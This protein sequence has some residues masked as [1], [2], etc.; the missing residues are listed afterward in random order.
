[1]H[2]ASCKMKFCKPF[3]RIHIVHCSLFVVLYA[4]PEIQTAPHTILTFFTF[5]CWLQSPIINKFQNSAFLVTTATILHRLMS[6][7]RHHHQPIGFLYLLMRDLTT[8][9]LLV[10]AVHFED[11]NWIFK[12]VYCIFCDLI[13]CRL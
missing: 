6:K 2:I 3:K 12:T 9:S 11:Q 5:G 7:Y 13:Y 1:M 10:I 8:N 4:S